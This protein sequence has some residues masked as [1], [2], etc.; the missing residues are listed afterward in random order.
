MDHKEGRGAVMHVGSS[1]GQVICASAA[2]TLLWYCF[3][4]RLAEL[5][6]RGQLGTLPW[7]LVFP[8]LLAVGSMLSIAGTSWQEK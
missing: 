3:D 7:T 2:A 5:L 8:L 1:A 6:G 4:D